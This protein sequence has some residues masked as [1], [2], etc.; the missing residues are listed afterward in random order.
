MLLS[1]LLVPAVEAT[2]CSSRNVLCE[3]KRYR[4]YY[5]V[6]FYCSFNDSFHLLLYYCQAI[7]E[8]WEHHYDITEKWGDNNQVIN[9]PTGYLKQYC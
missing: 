5:N 7:S 6:L 8:N 4:F 1:K 9:I 2:Q 3:R